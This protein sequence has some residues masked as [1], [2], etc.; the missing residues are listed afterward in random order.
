M[1][2]LGF[3][4][5]YFYSSKGGTSLNATT[6]RK[7]GHYPFVRHRWQAAVHLLPTLKLDEAMPSI[8][9]VQA[10]SGYHK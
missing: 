9:T 8:R 6:T 4:L 3:I 10:H 2:S 5:Y 1:P 7:I